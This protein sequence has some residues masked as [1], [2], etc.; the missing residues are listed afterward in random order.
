MFGHIFKSR[1]PKLHFIQETTIVAKICLKFCLDM[2][3]YCQLMPLWWHSNIR[4]RCACAYCDDL[5]SYVMDQYCKWFAICTGLQVHCT[6]QQQF[7]ITLYLHLRSGGSKPLLT[8]HQLIDSPLQEKFTWGENQQ[9]HDNKWKVN[10]RRTW[11]KELLKTIAK[12]GT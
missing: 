2:Y 3:R 1:Q 12:I 10:Y 7:V 4:I 8:A 5:Q 9:L 11:N 6:L